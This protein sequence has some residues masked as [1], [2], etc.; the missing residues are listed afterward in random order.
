MTRYNRSWLQCRQL[1][2]TVTPFFA[3][4]AGGFCQVGMD[5]VV[6]HIAG[7]DQSDGWHIDAGRIV[8]VGEARLENLEFFSFQLEFVAVHGRWNGEFFGYLAGKAGSPEAVYDFGPH[9]FRAFFCHSRSGYRDSTRKAVKQD[10]QTI[11]MVAMRM[12]DINIGEIFP[13]GGDRFGKRL[14]MF[15]GQKDIDQYGVLFTIDKSG[16]VWHPFQV[17]ETGRGV[18]ITVQ[19]WPGGCKYLLG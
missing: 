8:R 6:G 13:G 9:L 14:C 15:D 7:D 2:E 5:A 18:G 16:A 1:V 17:I 4:F 19:P 3:G 12:R 11:K 10:L